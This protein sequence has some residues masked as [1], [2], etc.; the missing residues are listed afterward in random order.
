MT[1]EDWASVRAVWESDER[2]GYTWA[3]SE[4][5][6]PVSVPAVRKRAIKEGWTKK[7]GN[8]KPTPKK[9][10]TRNQKPE[11]R[12]QKP[13]GKADNPRS[14]EKPK[15]TGRTA[16]LEKP[17][18]LDDDE[19]REYLYGEGEDTD[20]SASHTRTHTRDPGMSDFEYGD[21]SS[22]LGKHPDFN[23]KYRP[24]YSI[25][26]FRF[27][28]LG[29]TCDELADVIGV[30][31]ATLY[32]WRDKFPE[33][34]RALDGRNFA[35]ANIA[36]RLFQRAMG[37]TH[38]TEEIKIVND[39]VVRVPTVKHYPPDPQSLKFWLINR[40]PLLWKE[41]VEIVEQPEIA[42]LDK[43]EM[44]RMY[45]AA[46]EK[47]AQRRDELQSRSDRLGLTLDGESNRDDEII[48]DDSLGDNA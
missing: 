44:D 31:R 26:A 3:H 21:L 24:E 29:A 18:E 17:C 48:L 33:F 5:D 4:L 2:E 10:E 22:L 41:R 30:S 27:M 25:I 8:Q 40:Q 23:G 47:A 42:V 35:D 15:A 34:A 45:D 7:Q 37:Y 28:L 6:L 36:S 19:V 11:T 32:A 12:N 9:P 14:S 38:E 39:E 20:R 16:R 1:A 46:L 43:E 13:K